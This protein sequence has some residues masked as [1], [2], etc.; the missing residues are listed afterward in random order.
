MVGGGPCENRAGAWAELRGLEQ[1]VRE[2]KLG[3]E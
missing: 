3:V 2:K 1:H